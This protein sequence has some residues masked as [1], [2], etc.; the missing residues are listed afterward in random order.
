M[1]KP[2]TLNYV[3]FSNHFVCNIFL[4]IFLSCAIYLRKLFREHLL[5]ELMQA[6]WTNW[7]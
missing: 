5:L 3:S 7:T 6:T 4:K 2:N 1:M